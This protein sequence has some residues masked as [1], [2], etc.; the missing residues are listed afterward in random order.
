[1]Q[2][3]SSLPRGFGA[4]AVAF[5]LCI[6]PSSSSALTLEE[7]LKQTYETHPAL[8]SERRALAAIDERVAMAVSEWRPTVD[9]TYVT[10]RQRFSYGGAPDIYAD[11]GVRQL[12][13]NQ[14]LFD[15]GGTVARYRA[16]KEQVE[17]GRAQLR[18]V[19]QETLLDAI[20]VYMDVL[21]DNALLGLNEK[22][23]AVLEKQRDA[24]KDRFG[25]GEVTKTDVAQSEA[26]LSRA[27]SDYAVAQGAL[28]TSI[29]R[30][31]RVIGSSPTVLSVPDK[32]PLLPDTLETANVLGEEANPT[33]KRSVHLA[34]A[35]KKDVSAQEAELLPSVA[36]QAYMRREDGVGGIFGNTDYDNDAI[37]VNFTVPLY[38]SGAEYARVREA[39]QNR[40][41]AHFDLM[42]T[43]KEMNARIV[44]AWEAVQTSRSSIRAY[45]SAIQAAEQALEGVKQEQQYG[46]RTVLDVLDA[47][48]ELHL[49]HVGLVRAQRDETVAS[50]ALL[51][52]TGQ[53]TPQRLGMDVVVYNPEENY[54][55]VKFR[56]IGF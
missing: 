14:P 22:N 12:M 25:V 24:A 13:L 44:R 2:W 16:S 19:T 3:C 49:A 9:A 20:T 4:Y 48:Q 38:Q 28:S 51:A 36:L 40:T 18:A 15:G 17:A 32:M 55:R 23:V 37:T 6:S 1:M 47:E 30:F 26:R 5:G 56:A 35:R 10:G 45:N 53:L 54:E 43:R 39:R 46:A 52:E 41:R 33:L 11:R 31:E 34:E 42:D 8:Q 50:Y 7:A 21:R 27:Q 29:A